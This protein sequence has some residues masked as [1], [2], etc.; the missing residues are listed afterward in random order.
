M[1][2][3]GNLVAFSQSANKV[4]TNKLGA[5]APIRATV[6]AYRL[7]M[8]SAMLNPRKEVPQKLWTLADGSFKF[9]L[10]PNDNAVQCDDL[11]KPLAYL[12]ER[13]VTPIAELINN[14]KH[15]VISPEPSMIN[16]PFDALSTQ[17]KGKIYLHAAVALVP[18]M[19]IYDDLGTRKERYKKLVRTPYLGIGGAY[20]KHTTKLSKHI[21][22]SRDNGEQNERRLMDLSVAAQAAHND[23]RLIPIALAQFDLGFEDLP[24]SKAQVTE[25]GTLFDEKNIY[26]DQYASE[27]TVYRLE[28]MGKL[29]SF[30]YIHFAAHGYLSNTNP[31]L[32]SIVLTQVN[33]EAGTDGFLTAGKISALNLQSDLVVIASCDSGVGSQQVGEGVLG[34]TYSLFEAG[35]AASVVTLW[36]INGTSTPFMKHFYELI[37]TQKLEPVMALAETKKWAASQN[38]EPSLINAFVYYGQ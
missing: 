14:A 20:Y 29:S 5:V 16:V 25:I 34:L 36:P 28:D 15:I 10:K 22:Y 38:M 3:E 31:K 33:R 8:R 26:T 12:S 2:L 13:L 9:G 11:Q 21:S 18:S 6:E 32:S 19:Q 30:K 17:E 4:Q 35:T 27:A 37:T 23:P 7:A 1:T 24:S